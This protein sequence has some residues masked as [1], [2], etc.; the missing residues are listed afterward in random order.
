MNCCEMIHIVTSHFCD[1]GHKNFIS[2]STTN[3]LLYMMMCIL[4]IGI[5][6]MCSDSACT[7][8]VI[9]HNSEYLCYHYVINLSDSFIK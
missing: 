3:T 2:H 7:H 9:L 6:T 1:M 5:Y 8:S 4:H